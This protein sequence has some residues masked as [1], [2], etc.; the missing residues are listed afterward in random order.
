MLMEEKEQKQI[1][2]AK[3]LERISSPEQLN[4]YIK[5]AKPGVWVVLSAIII[6]L[7]GFIIWGCT[8]Q[9]RT[10]VPCILDNY[11]GYVYGY[12]SESDILSGSVQEGMTI[13]CEGLTV[14]IV[15]IDGQ[16]LE[17][18]EVLSEYEI[19]VGDFKDG[20]WI[21]SMA[22]EGA[23][24]LSEGVHKGSITTES[25]SPIYFILSRNDEG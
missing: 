24:S 8:A 6:L 9:I 17:A 11:Q 15:D 4:D 23:D 19:Y 22:V 5:V 18:A 10:T 1:F 3:S 13:D 7:V 12:V 25:I 21:Y 16:A 2:R 14:T 20:E